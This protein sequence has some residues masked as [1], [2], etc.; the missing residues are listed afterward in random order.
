MVEF[1]S[2]MRKLNVRSMFPSQGA[3][4]KQM[5]PA[6]APSP[7]A[8]PSPDQ[9]EPLVTYTPPATAL[10]VES[11]LEDVPCP[12]T[13]PVSEAGRPSALTPLIAPVFPLPAPVQVKRPDTPKPKST[14]F[15]KTTKCDD[16]RAPEA[17]SLAPVKEGTSKPKEGEFIGPACAEYE[18]YMV[19]ALFE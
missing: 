9:A 6:A 13:A 12:V 7:A 16:V 1:F 18:D 17:A 19:V 2:K 8:V 4:I 11:V 14:L 3:Q 5:P 15:S 10:I